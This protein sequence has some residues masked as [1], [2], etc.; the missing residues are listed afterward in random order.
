IGLAVVL[1]L[2]SIY[3]RQPVEFSVF[4]SLLLLLTLVRLSLNVASTRLVLMH[5]QEGVGAA[6]NVIMAFGQFVVGG[7]F[8]VGVVV[9]LVLIAIQYIVINHGAVRISEV[10]A[11]F[12]LDAMPGRQMAIDADLNAGVIDEKEARQRRERVRRE[13]DFY[14]AMD[15]AI[16]FTQRDALAAVLITGVNIVAGLI[17]GVMQHGLDLATA[18][19]TYTIL[20]VGEGLV[21]AIPA[22]LVSMSGGLIT[23]RAAAEA[24]LGEEVALQLFARPRPLAAAAAVLTMLA[25]IPGLPKVAFL[26]VA[27]V[28]AAAAYAVRGEAAQAAAAPEAPS[29]A[30]DGPEHVIGVD[31]ISVE[32]GYALVSLV[33]EKQ[34]GTLLSRVRA[35]RRQIANE[36]G[37]VVAPV[38]IADNLQLGPRGYTIL[39]KGVEVARGELYAE[40]LLAINP[41][42]A[43]E[44]LEGFHTQEA[45]FGL[46]ATWIATELRDAA[47]AA[48][49]TVVDATT[50]LSTHLSET[51]R[52][53][54]P[55]LLSRQQVKEMLDQVAQTSP[56]LV[57][58]LVP[59]TVSVGEVQ[60][61][62]RQL[63]R[64]RV[65][66]RDLVTILEALADAA[67][68]TKD[69]DIMTEVVRS[70]IG[71]AICRPY[72][73]EKGELTVIGVQPA[74]EE[75]LL[76]S[77][78]KTEQ[79][80]M[81]ALDPQ[82]AQSI[83]ARIARAVEQ[84]MAQP[85]L[86]CSPALRPHLWRLFA[87]VLPH[88]G[89][90]SHAEVPPHIQVVPVA[91][92]D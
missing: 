16:R 85:V 61:V 92:L 72:Q 53:F 91:T 75:R 88:L 80:A 38:R 33:D 64:E 50:A 22:L 60:R 57:E 46:P 41:G 35:I 49:Y 44:P 28:L 52:T 87:R 40:R 77:L 56:K 68:A 21:T 32:V 36:T 51:I 29:A 86:L 63:L 76:G 89:V 74:L 17:I 2:T 8:V 19:E 82:Q 10:T 84:A 3:V 73:N 1:L 13:A 48:G 23:T 24:H 5:G 25:L 66:V 47:S 14:G 71:R 4:P 12:T 55:D 59:K 67:A 42:A 54:L 20:T 62:L 15:G 65:P 43:S 31:P 81:L 79:G 27:A 30:P 18:A 69:P 34:G 6:G 9:F 39:I 37:V 70:A 78:V 26:S 83:A 7:N 45:A 90:L 11:R 58:E